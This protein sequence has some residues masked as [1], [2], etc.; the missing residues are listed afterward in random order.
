MAPLYHIS[1]LHSDVFM[2]PLNVY[3]CARTTLAAEDTEKRSYLRDQ[4][5]VST[6][7]SGTDHR[8]V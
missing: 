3:A 4:E 8:E 7:H 6:R 1:S 5:C 2:Y